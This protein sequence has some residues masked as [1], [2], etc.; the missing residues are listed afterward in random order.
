MSTVRQPGGRFWHGSLSIPAIG[1][2]LVRLES[3]MI[4]DQA[5][6]ADQLSAWAD[7]QSFRICPNRSTPLT[8]RGLAGCQ[9]DN[10]YAWM[11]GNSSYTITINVDV[12]T[13]A[14]IA[15]IDSWRVAG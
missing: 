2:K 12:T 9:V 13:E 15:W 8:I 14:A 5:F 6:T 11:D 3:I 1:I 4:G 7:D 10:Q